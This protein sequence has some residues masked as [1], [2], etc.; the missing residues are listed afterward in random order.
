MTREELNKE[1]QKKIIEEE[2][3]EKRKK[4]VVLIFKMVFILII[5]FVLFY[6]YTT[7][8]ST[9]SLIVKEERI[10]DNK[11]PSNFN[12][13]KIIHFSDLHYGSTIFEDE[14]ESVVK[15]IN[16]RKPDLV[17]FTGDLID[18]EYNLSTKELEKVIKQLKKIDASLGK[19]AITGEEDST[20]SNTIF[21]QSDFIVL[22]NSYEL[23]YKDN[24][25]PILLIG[26]SSLL[27][28]QRD[29]NKAY[30]YFSESTHN[31]DIFTISILH[32]PD[33]VSE[34]LEKYPTNLF[35][36]G[37]SHNGNI[38]IPYVGALKKEEGAKEYD[39]SF[40]QINDSKLYI[41]SGI[42][43]NGLGFRL[44]CRP[45]INFFRLSQE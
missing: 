41:S 14:L 2:N 39:Q 18:E 12:G 36:A 15:E 24:S 31:S 21:N 42:G 10:V 30:S 43:T 7:Y 32:E 35:L 5:A 40:Y 13:M 1:K 6:L 22:N 23:V 4:I 33:S 16:K 44:F 38:R 17:L 25:N 11:L 28:E 9:G 8:I 27:K 20:N 29:I 45:S 37:H 34:I 26:L 19:Y 3:R